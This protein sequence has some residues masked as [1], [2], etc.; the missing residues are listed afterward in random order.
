M[1]ES[2]GEIHN[3]KENDRKLMHMLV[4]FKKIYYLC[5]FKYIHLTKNTIL[6]L[7]SRNI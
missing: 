4:L 2:S 1:C 6:P 7:D 3:I 5:K